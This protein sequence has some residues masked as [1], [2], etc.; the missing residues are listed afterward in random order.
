MRKFYKARRNRVISAL[1]NCSYA[2]RLTI[3]EQDAGLHFL[4]NVDTS[5][6]DRALTELLAA[7][8]IRVHA[9][10]EYFHSAV[11]D[12]HCLVVNYAAIREDVLTQLLNQDLPAE[13]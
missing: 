8:G 11:G 6:S 3:L 9:L 1:K 7:S 12:L 5:L 13:R 10:S 2:S 4:L